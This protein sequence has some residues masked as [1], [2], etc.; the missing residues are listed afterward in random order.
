MAI[1]RYTVSPSEI[2]NG[3]AHQNQMGKLEFVRA[4][5]LLPFIK[6]VIMAMEAIRIVLGKCSQ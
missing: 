5:F 1:S 6:F 3:E 2:L 4:V